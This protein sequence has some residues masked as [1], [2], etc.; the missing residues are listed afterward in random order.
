MSKYAP[1]RDHLR[2]RGQSTWRASFA[3]V[4]EIVPLPP[5]AYRY[6]AWWANEP[7]GSH[8]QARSWLGAGW[9]TRDVDLA[10]RKVTFFRA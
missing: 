8:V 1:L 9:R 7:H 6:P 3:E 2:N 5:S 4:E 10:G